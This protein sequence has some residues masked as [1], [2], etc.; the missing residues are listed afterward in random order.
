MSFGFSSWKSV[1][2]TDC[3]AAARHSLAIIS[4]CDGVIL[5]STC[6]LVAPPGTDD[7]LQAVVQFEMEFGR[8]ARIVESRIN[9]VE[10]IG[11]LYENVEQIGAQS[12]VAAISMREDFP[13]DLPHMNP[14]STQFPA[15]PCIA[16]AQLDDFFRLVGLTGTIDSIRKWFI[17]ARTGSLHKDGWHPVPSP[18]INP[19]RAVIDIGKTQDIAK[20]NGNNWAVG[21]M[22]MFD[23]WAI[24]HSDKTASATS[25]D[26]HTIRDEIKSR[27]TSGRGEWTVPW[28]LISQTDST[29]CD[30]PFFDAFESL[31]DLERAM[32]SVG[33]TNL[34]EALAVIDTERLPTRRGKPH[35]D[36]CVGV[37][38][39]VHRP[40]P[41]EKT[42]PGLSTFQEARHY[43]VRAYI[44]DGLPTGSPLAQV[45]GTLKHVV[46]M[47]MPSA[48]L[49][50]HVSGSPR[51]TG[52]TL[53]GVGA[54]GSAIA[55]HL[56]RMGSESLTVVDSDILLPHNL[57]RHVG[58]YGD[59][60]FPKVSSIHRLSANLG[61]ML[62]DEL[63]TISRDVGSSDCAIRP[64]VSD[65]LTTSDEELNQCA[66]TSKTIIDSTANPD[67]RKRL[68]R[69]SQA[70][71]K[72]IVR[73]EAYHRGLLGVL[74][75]ANSDNTPDI[76]DLYFAL[77][78][79]RSCND[80]VREWLKW[81]RSG[82]KGEHELFLGLGCA[83][84]TTQL[85]GYFVS[86]H[87]AAFMPKISE[88]LSSKEKADA[89]V[90]INRL[91]ENG[92]PLGWDWY[93]IPPFE[94][95][96]AFESP[97]SIRWHPDV[98]PQLKEYR[99]NSIPNETGGYLYGH[100]D[101]NLKRISLLLG[102]PAPDGSKGTPTELSLESANKDQ[103]GRTFIRRCAGR[104]HLVG[105]WHSH[106]GGSAMP[107]PKDL[108]TIV[109]MVVENNQRGIPTLMVILA[110][111][112]HKCILSIENG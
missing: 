20:A 103:K 71:P 41:L 54:L 39:A 60:F 47:P 13:R 92:Y 112:E 26:I 22:T 101:Y 51:L 110:D 107:S 102:T 75:V 98:L 27:R 89:G 24:F 104:I 85:P 8:P 88:I 82:G 109:P 58:R 12:P 55:E 33:L 57:A 94:V 25:N 87:A 35:N 50:R 62:W 48:P 81:E 79:L 40:K 45:N 90:G 29:E 68:C 46:N 73:A 52:A 56:V 18:Q 31:S 14:V 100:W 23:D 84:M 53:V 28:V 91:D 1:P 106:P 95:T 6:I 4:S 111:N 96:E 43:E 74:S 30:V 65:V 86:N 21:A 44:L 36:Q 3:P 34:R 83:S 97:W 69:Y 108:R 70:F 93:E 80:G 5:N 7:E 59:L 15:S 38:V 67:I 77:L 10:P 105:T 17:D 9:D 61:Q 42:W 49:F 37:V 19:I 63:T 2:H 78:L 32:Q 16:W 99:R 72:S 76:Q 66:I 11:L 64:I